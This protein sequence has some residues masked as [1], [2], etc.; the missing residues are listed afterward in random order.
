M[1]QFVIIGNSAAGIA[2]VEAIRKK[3]KESKIV[4]I[5]DEDYP[6]YCRCL[7]SYYLSGEVKEDKILY[8]PEEFYKENN[9]ELL[10]NKEA[11]RVDTA[12]SRV[13]CAD[14]SQINYDALLIATGASPKIPDIT[15]IKKTGVFKF[16]TIK[17]A[18]DIAAQLPVLKSACILG[19]GL[20][21]LKAAYGL[22]KRNIEVKVI[23]KS[24]QVLSQMLDFESAALIQKR[25]EENG[26]E[27]IL[28]E[29]AVEVIGNG[30]IKAV[31]LESGKALGCS[32]IVVG[33]GVSPNIDLIKET[34]IKFNEGIVSDK[35]MQ[36]NIPNIYTAGDVCET[37]DITTNEYSIN[38]LWPVAV[39]QGRIA[40]SNMSGERLEY[41]G[42]IGMNSIEFFGLAAV[43]LGVYKAKQGDTY[44][45]ELKIM[46]AKNNLYKKLILKNDFL[47]G[48]IL[49]G[50]IKNSGVLLR[51]IREKINVAPFKDKLLQENFGYPDI[52]DFV[53]EDISY[54]AGY[55]N[56]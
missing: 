35:S 39:E 10:L 31:K 5:S 52:K 46:D 40:G 36:S 17:D 33:K 29:D 55:L 49:T 34:K 21:G 23:V 9:I 7:I 25:L 56:K 13:I 2:A 22:K 37:L 20:I 12:K 50:D 54:G 38:A 8:R 1:K 48:A 51:I 4:V 47:I 53:S 30:D 18:K 14:K 26:I 45:E 3:D 11:V 6:S 27:L 24:R 42:S 28:G 15:G 41:D 32:L 19:G 43:S 44:C 16:R